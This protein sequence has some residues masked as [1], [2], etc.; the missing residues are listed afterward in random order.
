MVGL[1]MDIGYQWP[2][3]YE[4]GKEQQA[5]LTDD[6][7]KIEYENGEID[8]TIRC[9]LN[10]PVHDTEEVFAFGIWMSVSEKS[11]EI[12]S[13][14]FKSGVFE[15][16]G[17]FG[18]LYNFLPFAKTTMLLQANVTFGEGNDRP[19]VWLHDADHPLIVAQ[20]DGVSLNQVEEWVASVTRHTH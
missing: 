16:P 17:C 13:A 20:R 7:C 6:F 18:Y 10:I 19:V 8:R 5:V 12:Y 11:W 14:G 1:P 9:I 15:K 3:V 2:E 4:P